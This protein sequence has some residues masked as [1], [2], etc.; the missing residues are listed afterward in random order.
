MNEMMPSTFAMNKA[1]QGAD[2]RG[3]A[4]PAYAPPK[5]A[6]NAGCH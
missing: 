3:G 5:P 4:E 6:R 1:V 2:L